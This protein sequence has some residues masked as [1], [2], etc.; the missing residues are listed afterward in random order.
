MNNLAIALDLGGTQ[1]RA[2]LVDREGHVLN[3]VAVP[4]GS[5]DG[6]DAVLRQLLDAALAMK[7]GMD[8]DRILGVGVCAPGPLNAAKGISLSM[9]TIPG[10]E[11]VNLRKPLEHALDLPVW[12]ENDATA[13]ALGE[14]RFGAG[15]GLENFVY[16]TVSTGIGGGIVA[17]NRLLRGRLGL[18]GEVGHMTIVRNG[19]TCSCGNSGCWEAYASG[20]AFIRRARTRLHTANPGLLANREA[21]LSGQ[22][23]FDAAALGDVLAIELVLEEAEF[24][25]IGI[26][27]LIHLYSPQAILVGGGM[28]TH[29]EVLRPAISAKVR[30]AA[31]R[32]F[33]D[34]PII[35]AALNG[36]SGLIGAAALVFDAVPAMSQSSLRSA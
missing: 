1:V 14:W 11:N 26:A 24:L 8:A 33:E 21:P 35:R 16:I 9:P 4:T 32:G 13:A 22:A 34:V 15:A 23:I 7:S 30:G 12:L 3:R 36:N 5:A 2:A 31:M 10:F 20:T 19:D 29:L 25:G 17:D 6:A 28:S 27:N 18:A